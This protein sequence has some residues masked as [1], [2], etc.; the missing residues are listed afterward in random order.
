MGLRIDGPPLLLLIFEHFIR[1]DA[2]KCN[3]L[4]R[5]FKNVMG[6][7]HSRLPDPSRVR[8]FS[9]PTPI[10]PLRSLRFRRSGL[11]LSNCFRHPCNGLLACIS[12]T[13]AGRVSSSAL[14]GQFSDHREIGRLTTAERE[15]ERERLRSWR[16]T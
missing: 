9:F 6:R 16:S 8:M 1:R 12:I 14:A 10:L 2:S 3:I 7:G 13:M 4:R 5:K 15:R 11:P